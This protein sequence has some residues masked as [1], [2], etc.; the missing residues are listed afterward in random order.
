[1][2][3][4]KASQLMRPL[5]IGSTDVNQGSEESEPANE[6]AVDG[7]TDGNRVSEESEP[8]NEAAKAKFNQGE[9]AGQRCGWS[10]GIDRWRLVAEIQ[11]ISSIVTQSING[12]FKV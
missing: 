12:S 11:N 7:S 3:R 4:E 6:A 10:S 1:M 8:V 9:L 2:D 5:Q